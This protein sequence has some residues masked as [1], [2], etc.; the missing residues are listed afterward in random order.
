[1]CIGAG[2][3]GGYLSSVNQEIQDFRAQLRVLLGDAQKADIALEGLAEFELKTP[4]EYRESIEA[5][6]LLRKMGISPTMEALTELGNVAAQQGKSINYVAEA[7]KSA[8]IGMANPLEAATGAI[9]QYDAGGKKLR[10]TYQGVTTTIDRNVASIGEWVRSIGRMPSVAGAAEARMKTLGGAMSNMR[11]AVYRLAVAIGD[12]GFS[13]DLGS[14]ANKIGDVANAI[15]TNG[16]Q[17]NWWYRIISLGFKQVIRSVTAAFKVM[18]NLGL[19]IG[20]SLKKT[21]TDLAK[22]FLLPFAGLE[23]VVQAVNKRLGT[24]IQTGLSGLATMY[25]N[26]DRSSADSA[27]NISGALQGISDALEPVTENTYDLFKALSEGPQSTAGLDYTV[28][29]F[30]QIATVTQTAAQAEQERAAAYAKTLD[31]VKVLRKYEIESGQ[32]VLSMAQREMLAREAVR[33]QMRFNN[34]S[35]PEARAEALGPMQELNK[36]VFAPDE[37]ERMN[38]AIDSALNDPKTGI[39]AA[40]NRALAEMDRGIIARALAITPEDMD[41]IRSTMELLPNAT[42]NIFERITKQGRL[43]ARSIAAEF[44]QS[45]EQVTR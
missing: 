42:D 40:T 15:R 39:E 44:D 24:N 43:S 12:A 5:F 16:S 14:L 22:T 20:F 41:F 3:M 18:W 33:A 9:V 34:A 1:L 29:A 37:M 25:D 28:D 23:A 45:F 13:K 35:T 26:L 11:G 19:A 10:I 2:A 30:N 31:A 17:I 21:F 38:K 8:S 4:F 32:R 36:L 6:I 7:I 27:E